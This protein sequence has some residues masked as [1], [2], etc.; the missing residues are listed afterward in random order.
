MMRPTHLL[1]AT[2]LVGLG[3]CSVLRPA[4]PMDRDAGYRLDRG[5]AALEASRYREAFDDLAWVHS[6]CSGTM[7]GVEALIALAALELDPLNRAARP[8][9]GADLLGRVIREPTAPPWVRPLARTAYLM[10]LSLGAD[11]APD[12]VA[13]AAADSPAVARLTDVPTPEGDTASAPRDTARPVRAAGLLDPAPEAT[14]Y[15]C[16]PTISTEGWVTP[17]LPELPGPSLVAQLSVAETSRD[18]AASRADTLSTEVATLRR[19]LAETQAELERIR[20]TLRP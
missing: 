2:M 13:A 16:G 3:A 18:R 11:P 10:A 7:R 19:Q 17:R 5:L 15:G 12:A 14:A 20:R 4:P 6:H 9:L 8:D 1:V